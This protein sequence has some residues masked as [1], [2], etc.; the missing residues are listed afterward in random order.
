MHYDEQYW[1]LLVDKI[2]FGGGEILIKEIER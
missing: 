2:A 1:M